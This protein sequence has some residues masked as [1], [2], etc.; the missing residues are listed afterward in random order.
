[1]VERELILYFFESSTNLLIF[2]LF[3]GM[4]GVLLAYLAVRPMRKN[5]SKALRRCYWG[6]FLIICFGIAILISPAL[7]NSVNLWRDCQSPIILQKEGTLTKVKTKAKIKVLIIDGE[8][9]FLSSRVPDLNRDNYY[10]FEYLK[11]SK[12]IVKIYN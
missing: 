5:I 1:M 9:Y 2:Y 12:F 10:E 6:V 3:A 8:E 4:V 7:A 11:N